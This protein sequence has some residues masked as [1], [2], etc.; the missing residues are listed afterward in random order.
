MLILKLEYSRIKYFA[1]YLLPIY[2]NTLIYKCNENLSVSAPDY[3]QDTIQRT[4]VLDN[5]LIFSL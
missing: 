3:N 5:M 2:N 4:W 1:P